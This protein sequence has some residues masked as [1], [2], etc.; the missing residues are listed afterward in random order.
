MHYT[1]VIPQLGIVRAGLLGVVDLR[2]LAVFDVLRGM[3]LMR[4]RRCI[5]AANREF[6]WAHYAHVIK[7]LPLVFNPDASS[8][9]LK[10]Q[11]V[12]IIAKL[13]SAGLVET[14]RHGRRQF[15]RLTDLAHKLHQPADHQEANVTKKHDGAKTKDDANFI[16]PRSDN[17]LA[18]NIYDPNTKDPNTILSNNLPTSLQEVAEELKSLWATYPELQNIARWTKRR[19]E[20]LNDRL[21][22]DF[23]ART[24]VLPFNES[25]RALSVAAKASAAG[26][27]MWIGFLNRTP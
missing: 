7:E 5:V 11:L 1:L 12:R 14:Q 25:H 26:G 23:S 21:N 20:T 3:S 10:N 15:F 19:L 16:T 2:D 17:C 22:D 27:R 9:T 18:P 24:G 4:N 13:R 8:A 6:T